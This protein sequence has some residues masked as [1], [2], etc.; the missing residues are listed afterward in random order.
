[1]KPPRPLRGQVLQALALFLS[2]LPA[3]APRHAYASSP[4]AVIVPDLPSKASLDD[5][6]V[7]AAGA[8]YEQ[9]MERHRQGDLKGAVE[10]G[11]RTYKL[12]PAANTAFL[13]AWILSEAKR[14]CEAFESLLRAAD[15]EL[16]PDE[17][18]QVSERLPEEARLCGSGFGWIKLEIATAGAR[19]SVG[20]IQVPAGRNVGVHAGRHA[21]AIEAPGYQ[22]LDAFIGVQAGQAHQEMYKLAPTP[23]PAPSHPPNHLGTTADGPDNTISWVL[24]GTGGAL[25]AAGAGLYVWAL[26]AKK[27][28]DAIADEGKDGHSTFESW[29]EY[30]AAKDDVTNRSTMA[31]VS[32]GLGAASIV[33]GILLHSGGGSEAESVCF[34]PWVVPGGTGIR[35]TA[36]F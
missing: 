36:P 34:E 26:D 16:T 9:M 2:L 13:L 25:V 30:N 3:A 17:R 24:I 28:A 32:A 14:H 29:Q 19:V 23:T 4:P 6:A 20:G 12:A 21:L 10:A 7:Q 5:D 31:Y 11:R 15:L 1:M 33:A 8:A 27:V 18:G 35:L 22:R